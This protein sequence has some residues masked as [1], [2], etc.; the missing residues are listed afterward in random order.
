[1][2]ATRRNAYTAEE[3]DLIEYLLGQGLPPH[4][5]AVFLCPPTTPSGLLE[6]MRRAG[7]TAPN[8][9]GRGRP[10]RVDVARWAQTEREL[11]RP[12]HE[13]RRVIDRYARSRLHEIAE[14]CGYQA[15]LTE[16]PLEVSASTAVH[17]QEVTV[18]CAPSGETIIQDEGTDMDATEAT[19]RAV[20]QYPESGMLSQRDRVRAGLNLSILASGPEDHKLLCEALGVPANVSRQ[21]RWAA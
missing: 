15:V 18:D 20:R 16:K 11:L 3:Y 9:L 21:A 7:I 1:M 6:A 5:I 12:G 4:R 10:R 2:P 8:P 13:V 19:R 14:R 17:Q